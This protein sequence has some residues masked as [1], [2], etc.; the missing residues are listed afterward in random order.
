M[1]DKQLMVIVAVPN[2]ARTLLNVIWQ[3]SRTGKDMVGETY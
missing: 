3:I 1:K 2:L